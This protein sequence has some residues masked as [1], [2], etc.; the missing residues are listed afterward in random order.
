VSRA[1]AQAGA[2][3]RTDRSSPAEVRRWIVVYAGRVG[4]EALQ[5]NGAPNVL[6]TAEA[7]LHRLARHVL[8]VTPAKHLG[9]CNTCSGESDI[10]E[11]CCPYCGDGEMVDDAVTAAHLAAG[12]K[13]EAERR[14]DR[15]VAAVH[16]LK[17]TAVISYW[18]LGQAVLTCY[19]DSLWRERVDVTTGER[20]YP[21]WATFCEAELRISRQHSYKM[22]SVAAHYSSDD[23]A[24]LGATKLQLLLQLNGPERDRLL[25][26]AKQGPLSTSALAREIRQLAGHER[27]KPVPR[28]R[29]RAERV[30]VELP[31][32]RGQVPLYKRAT[33]TPGP[34]PRASRLADDPVGVLPLPGGLEMYMTVQQ[35]AQGLVIDYE[36]RRASVRGPQH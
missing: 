20:M 2:L 33:R 26:K 18:Q 27:D 1:E 5:V 30:A 13:S 12:Q 10:T 19:R 14:L 32:E 28:A 36:V 22:M 24:E 6:G 25:E 3:P 31:L 29:P 15:A 9:P 4:G 35:T 23:V 11:E 8:A 17:Q 21:T 34:P 16:S 7:Q